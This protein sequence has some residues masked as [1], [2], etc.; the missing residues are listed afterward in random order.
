MGEIFVV[1]AADVFL[2]FQQMTTASPKLTFCNYITTAVDRRML[3]FANAV[4]ISGG[5]NQARSGWP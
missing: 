3:F 5:D 2:L 1:K 4:V